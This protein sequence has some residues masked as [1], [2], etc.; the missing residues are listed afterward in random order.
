MKVMKRRRNFKSVTF[1]MRAGE[2]VVK[3]QHMRLPAPPPP[4]QKNMQTS[5]LSMQTSL[6]ASCFKLCILVTWMV[7][8]LAVGYIGRPS[9]HSGNR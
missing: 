4:P 5:R 2:T 7:D 3:L 6:Y 8:C 1:Q 9:R